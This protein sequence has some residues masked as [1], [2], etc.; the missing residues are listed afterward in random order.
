MIPMIFAMIIVLVLIIF[1][2]LVFDHSQA[3][4]REDLGPV[5]SPVVLKEEELADDL[6]PSRHLLILRRN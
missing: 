5:S 3:E 6:G 4:L 2:Y 1:S